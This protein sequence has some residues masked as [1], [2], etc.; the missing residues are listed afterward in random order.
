VTQSSDP[1]AVLGVPRDATDSQIAQARR[2]LSRQYHPDVNS[3]PDAEARFE[4]VQEAFDLLSDPA[5]RAKYDRTSGH[6]GTAGHPGAARDPGSATEVAPGI[7]VQPTAVDFGVL[8]P[9]RPSAEAKVT[10]AWTGAWPE[11]MT[12]RQGNEWWT[13]LGSETPA[14]SSVVFRLRATAHAGIPTGRHDA[15]FRVTLDGTRVTIPLTAEV[16]GVFPPDS[17]P[18][19]RPYRPARRPAR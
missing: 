11:R 2:R 18:S 10:V 9:S 15:D 6:R 4:E 7:F 1:Y 3:A 14:S 16:R 8:E 17:L 5:A 19:Y 12:S 13:N